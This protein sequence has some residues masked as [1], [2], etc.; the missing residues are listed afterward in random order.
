MSIC[1][2]YFYRHQMFFS[3][4]LNNFLGFFGGV[5]FRKFW[6]PK[7]PKFSKFP[8]N[9]FKICFQAISIHEHIICVLV[10]CIF[11]AMW[12]SLGVNR[13]NA[14]IRVAPPPL[15]LFL[16][17]SA[18]LIKFTFRTFFVNLL[19]PHLALALIKFYKSQ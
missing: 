13:R 7:P 8:W 16:S 18:K 17:T 9:L 1:P 4:H 5:C 19:C 12:I 14:R 6:P 2:I 11:K 15:P 3:H 10:Y